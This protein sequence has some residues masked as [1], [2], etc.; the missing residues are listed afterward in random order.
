[1]NIITNTALEKKIIHLVLEY[2]DNNNFK[3]YDYETNEVILE[4]SNSEWIVR[5]D[6]PSKNTNI[7][8]KLTN[9]CVVV[10]YKT[11]IISNTYIAN[12]YTRTSQV[13]SDYKYIYLDLSF[14]NLSAYN[15]IIYQT[16]TLIIRYNSG[17][18]FYR[19]D[20]TLK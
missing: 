7:I 17:G 6:T 2:T 20:I 11:S 18:T 3:L 12:V 16:Q 5:M 9:K 8:S 13:N 10:Y 14:I 19:K 15:E 4:I 1:M